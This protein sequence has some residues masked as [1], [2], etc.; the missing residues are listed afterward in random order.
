M[1]AKVEV[2]VQVHYW[3]EM[4]RDTEYVEEYVEK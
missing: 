2:P 4:Q 1:V 3:G